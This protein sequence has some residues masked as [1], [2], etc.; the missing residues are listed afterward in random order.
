ML[1]HHPGAAAQHHPSQQGAQNG[2]A[3]A[4]PGGGDAVLPA[5]LSGVAYEDH[6]REVGC[7]IGKGGEPGTDGASAQH[8]AID[9]G[10][11]FAAVDAN[12]H[13]NTEEDDQHGNFD[14][15][16]NQ[17][18]SFCDTLSLSCVKV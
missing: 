7:T 8:K 13:H 1:G 10:S 3:D 4:R 9:I 17:I 2:V 15:H 16:E 12:A 5:K 6:G 14:K 11:V 18:L